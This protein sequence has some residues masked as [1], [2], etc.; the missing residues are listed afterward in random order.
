MKMRLPHLGAAAGCLLGLLTT[1]V[2][3]AEMGPEERADREAIRA[4]LAAIQSI[5]AEYDLTESVPPRPG[6]QGVAPP[7]PPRRPPARGLGEPEI[8]AVRSGRVTAHRFSFLRGMLRIDSARSPADLEAARDAGVDVAIHSTTTVKDGVLESLTIR[9]GRALGTIRPQPLPY[10]E[11][12]IGVGLGLQDGTPFARG[13]QGG[14]L[15]DK[16]MAASAWRRLPSGAVVLS[17]P[18]AV[19]QTLEFEFDPKSGYAL[20]SYRRL[21]GP[22]RAVVSEVTAGKFEAVDGAPLPFEIVERSL[23]LD[24]RE[25]C[26]YTAR[27]K[28]YQLRGPDNHPN[29]YSIVWPNGMSVRRHAHRPDHPDYP[30]PRPWPA[31]D[32][33]HP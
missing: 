26:R 25:T 30:H 14:W 33:R 19:G 11:W 28:A 15:T 7:A 20:K 13:V 8:R 22:A 12:S 32:G 27:V 21:H 10:A 3:R 24:G 6:R 31:A 18:N 1:A 4:R 5:Q 29:H 17:R 9:R 16:V 2:C 23:D